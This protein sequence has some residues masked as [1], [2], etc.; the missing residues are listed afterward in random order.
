MVTNQQDRQVEIAGELEQAARTLARSTRAV[1]APFDSY[2]LLGELTMTVDHLEQV[3]AQLAEWHRGVVDGQHYAGED[4]RGDGAT[5]TITAA[6]QL[7]QA[8][9]ALAA[10]AA[11]L[12]AA[13]A[14][15]G[16][17]RWIGE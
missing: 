7:D 4:D 2:R 16:I 14:A 10:A 11:A 13:H 1:P 6:T 15:N 3:C 12:G 17:V 8:R 9:D 5:G